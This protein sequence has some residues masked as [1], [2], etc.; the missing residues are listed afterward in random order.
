MATRDVVIFGAEGLAKDTY[1][2]I[3]ENNDT[4]Y[5]TI[6]LIGFIDE[7]NYNSK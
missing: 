3:S 7:I 2:I 5:D 4:I 6:N 1:H